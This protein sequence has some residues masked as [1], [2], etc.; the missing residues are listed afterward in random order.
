MS[1]PILSVE[2]LGKRYQLSHHHDA[3]RYATLRDT[4]AGA[5]TAPFRRSNGGRPPSCFQL[6]VAPG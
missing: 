4:I 1:D 2:A 6:S 3:A 5:L